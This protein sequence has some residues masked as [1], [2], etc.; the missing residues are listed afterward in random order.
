MASDSP[1]RVLFITSSRTSYLEDIL[2][3]GLDEF[4]GSENVLCYPYK[5]YEDFQY[6]LHPPR[7]DSP[8]HRLPTGFLRL[9]AQKDRIAA[10]VVGSVQ[11]ESVATWRGIQDEFPDRPVGVINDGDG[12]WPGELRYTHRFKKNL[13]PGEESADLF[14]LCTAAPP[15]VM[16][17]MEETRD[18]QVSLVARPTHELRRQCAEVLAD[19][20]FLALYGVDLPREQFC[21]ILN[22]SKIAVSVRGRAWDTFRYWEIP[23][24]G[25]LLLSQ[26]LPILIPDDFIDGESAV[27]F[28]T[29]REMMDRITDLLA[30]AH[31]RGAGQVRP[32][33]HGFGRPAG[34]LSP[35]LGALSKNAE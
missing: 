22:R 7:E 35:P 5:D 1:P 12:E 3:E 30:E 29:P 6:N 11:P 10:V 18:I 8:P 32:Q 2:H 21:S 24:H 23:F 17:A 26:R 19:R 4:L 16:L 27:F 25:A 28:D 15:R 33:E 20:G 14:P 31:G 9:L 34:R 13:L